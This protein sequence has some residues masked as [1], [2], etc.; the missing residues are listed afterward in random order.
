MAT[1]T[2]KSGDTL[3]AIAQKYGTTYQEIAKANGISNPN[4]IYPGQTIN[5]GSD[6]TPSASDTTSAPST[7]PA[8]PPCASW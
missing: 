2:V 1:Y 3:S 6:N 8:T 4:L 7:T 5:I